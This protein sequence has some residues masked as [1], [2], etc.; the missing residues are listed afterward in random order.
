MELILLSNFMKNETEKMLKKIFNE[1]EGRLVNKWD[2]YLD[3]YEKHL[4]Q[5]VGS[6]CRILEIGVAQ[7]GSLEIWR[8]YLGEKAK[9]IG[10]DIN[11][12]C[13]SFESKNTKIVIGSQEDRDFLRKLK[14][15]E[16]KFDV[17]IDD[18]GHMMK[19]QIITFEELFDHVVDG[20]LYI[21]E[22]LHTSY[23]KEFGGGIGES[24]TFIE[25]SKNLIDEL[26]AWHS[27]N[28]DK[29][30]PTE[31]TKNAL[32]MHYY[33]SFLV[34]EKGLR[35][36]PKKV[37]KGVKTIDDAVFSSDPVDASDVG[38][39]KTCADYYND[40]HKENRVLNKEIQKK[41]K[42]I[43]KKNEEIQKK[44]KEIQ[45]KNEEIQKKNEEIQEKSKEISLL[46]SSKFFRARNLYM[47]VKKTLLPW[48]RT[49]VSVMD[50]SKEAL[51][52]KKTE[53]SVNNDENLK[54]EIPMTSLDLS[55]FEI[56]KHLSV[57]NEQNKCRINSINWFIPSV[58]HLLFGGIYTI[59]R[60]A[61]YFQMKG[62]QSRVI[63]YGGTLENFNKLKSQIP[64]YFKNLEKRNIL[65]FDGDLD[66]IPACDATI[67]TLWNSCFISAKFNKTKKKFYFIQDYEPL[68]F[69][70][71]S[72]RFNLSELTYR[73]G[74]RGIINTPGLAKYIEREHGLQD[75]KYFIPSVDRNIFNFDRSDIDKKISQD[76]LNIVF[77]GRPGNDR[78]AFETGIEALIRIKDKFGDK[79]NIFSVGADWKEKDYGVEGK[80]K[81]LGRL[82]SIEEVASIYK[83]SDIGLVFMFTKHPSYQPFEYMA[84]GCAVVTNYNADNLW[85]LK[86]RS[87]CLLFEPTSSCI[88]ESIS[89]LIER[90]ELRKEL[91]LNGLD[92]VDKNSWTEQCETIYEYI[93][94]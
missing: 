53:I 75:Y 88:V 17:I 54:K 51:K 62:I 9:I 1:H 32:G 13:K 8:K 74:F 30:S 40:Q 46:K 63:V 11:P 89:E 67:S 34:I 3:I 60:F 18:G 24:Q 69:P 7:G 16:E 84:S 26:N 78:N 19:Q 12:L 59:L 23:W 20:G 52:N 93:N 55:K 42:E 72:T 33:D 25:Y 57:I 38:S 87:N 43:Q 64:V 48:N 71:G 80:I 83:K 81:N 79:V 56:D 39:R 36:C 86:D 29:F 6:D 31:F 45:K 70:A 61:D 82:S 44:N 65:L 90:K 50:V 35:E 94:N 14:N 92:S 58:Q 37:K 28:L 49:V 76:N 15:T 73:L 21:C 77:Y 22:D 47:D 27:R 85:F 4:S 10:M 41:N 66:N 91:I 5:Y 2:H 68:F